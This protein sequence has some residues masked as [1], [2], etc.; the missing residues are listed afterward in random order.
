MR[1]C[2]VKML[3]DLVVYHDGFTRSEYYS[4]QTVTFEESFAQ[5]RISEGYCHPIATKETKPL[6]AKRETK[7][8]H[9]RSGE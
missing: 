4:G 1:T 7:Q 6:K 5:L 3:K 2:E 8:S 9:N